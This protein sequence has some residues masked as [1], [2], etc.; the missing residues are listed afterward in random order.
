MLR[1]AS[2][3]PRS[4]GRSRRELNWPGLNPQSLSMTGLGAQAYLMVLPQCKDDISGAQLLHLVGK[5]LNIHGIHHLVP[6]FG[7]PVRGLGKPSS[8]LLSLERSP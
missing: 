3:L 8:F 1:L 4:I 2:A 7:C 5:F 6:A